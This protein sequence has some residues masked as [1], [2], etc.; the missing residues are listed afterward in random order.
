[1]LRPATRARWPLATTNV[2]IIALC[3]ELASLFQ[4]K[5]MDLQ[6]RFRKGPRPLPSKR[7]APTAA[8][9]ALLQQVQ[10]PRIHRSRLLLRSQL[11]ALQARTLLVDLE[12]SYRPV[13][14]QLYFVIASIR[15][16]RRADKALVPRSNTVLTAPY[17]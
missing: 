2:G 14:P 4:V 8:P 5:P 12:L 1:M 16:S 7:R 15:R 10:I 11:P 6:V 17:G 3:N 9:L 13:L